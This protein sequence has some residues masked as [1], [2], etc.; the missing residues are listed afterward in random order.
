MC[1]RVY[2]DSDKKSNVAHTRTWRMEMQGE[3]S[4]QENGI[5]T[6]TFSW[7]CQE[8]WQSMDYSQRAYE[9]KYHHH[10]GI[11]TWDGDM[12]TRKQ[13]HRP[14]RVLAPSTRVVRDRYRM[15]H[16]FGLC[17]VQ[18]TF[19]P[20]LAEKKGC[21][22]RQHPLALM[23]SGITSPTLYSLINPAH[24]PTLLFRHIP[25]TRRISP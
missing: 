11:E 22:S 4:R 6:H 20:S 5:F 14:E 16:W 18:V 8:K 2:V 13:G 23:A 7:H 21:F 9:R 10:L 1:L 3:P 15:D 25:L 19:D 17:R 12:K 24:P